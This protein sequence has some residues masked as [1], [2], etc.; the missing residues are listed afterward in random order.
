MLAPTYCDNDTRSHSF[1]S[2]PSEAHIKHLDL[3]YNFTMMLN[4]LILT[5]NFTMCQILM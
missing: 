3:F 1:Y 5:K 2:E 4:I